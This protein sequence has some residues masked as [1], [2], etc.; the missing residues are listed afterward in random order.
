MVA[1]VTRNTRTSVALPAGPAGTLF[2]IHGANETSEGLTANVTRIEDQVRKR[3]WDVQVVAPEWRR[4]SGLRLGTW[5]KALYRGRP[6]PLV[7]P[8]VR[9][10]LGKAAVMKL[11][12]DYFEGRRV[13]LLDTLGAQLLADALG[14]QKHRASIQEVLKTELDEGGQGGPRPAGPAG[15]AQPR[16][17]RPGRPD[18][19]LARGA[20]SRR[21]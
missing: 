11:V 13:A 7:V 20:R 12:T 4:R 21:A 17:D 10:G 14:Y 5:Q 8:S 3:G 2:F 1:V 18:G 16:R 9:A 6:A 19:E 15:R